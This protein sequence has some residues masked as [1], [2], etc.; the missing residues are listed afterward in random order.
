MAQATPVSGDGRCGPGRATSPPPAGAGAT[1]H[2]IGLAKVA[3]RPT[4]TG[5]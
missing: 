3:R 2:I 4:L 1:R 5:R